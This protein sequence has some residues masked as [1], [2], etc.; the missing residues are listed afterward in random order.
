MSRADEGLGCGQQL[1]QDDPSALKEI[2]GLVKAKMT[3]LD[4]STMKSV[5]PLFLSSADSR[6]VPE[7]DL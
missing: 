3:G 1:R 7:P 5:P 4:P 2:I 6:P